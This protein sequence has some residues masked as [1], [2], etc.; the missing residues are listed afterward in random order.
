MNAHG[1]SSPLKDSAVL[2]PL[3][4]RLR[5]AHGLSQRDL[6]K[7]LCTSSMIS[8]LESGRAAPSLDLLN[9]LAKRLEVSLDYFFQ[10]RDLSADTLRVSLAKAHLAA[11]RYDEALPLL[12]DLLNSTDPLPDPLDT[13]MD[14]CT[15]C[16]HLGNT[17]NTE[18]LLQFLSEHDMNDDPDFQA[19][20]LHVQ[21]QLHIEA[22]R[23]HKAIPLLEKSLAILDSRAKASTLHTLARLYTELGD[24]EK[25][26][27]YCEQAAA[28]AGPVQSLL[29]Q[30]GTYLQLAKNCHAKQHYS[31]SI[32]YADRARALAELHHHRLLAEKTKLQQASLRNK[33]DGRELL[34]ESVF[35]IESEIGRDAAILQFEKKA[36]D[37]LAANQLFDYS[38]DLAHLAWILAD[39]QDFHGA[40]NLLLHA[41]TLTQHELKKRGI[42]L[43]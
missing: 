25:A 43:T 42:Q 36:A 14:L 12:Q 32:H 39:E 5:Q 33:R 10:E 31:Q 18:R 23:Y 29:D 6:A 35:S 8:Q 40:C 2:G 37:H 38:D 21:S 26:K 1:N 3:L 9:Q 27:V 19:R 15:C 17:R 11:R 4:K 22:K 24:L 34:A 20:L 30:A 28:V 7:D 13:V 16:L 41:R